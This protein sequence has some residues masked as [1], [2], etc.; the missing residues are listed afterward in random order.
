MLISGTLT[1][2]FDTLAEYQKTLADCVS[3]P[4]VTIN[5]SDEPS[6]TLTA[7]LDIDTSQPIPAE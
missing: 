3:S 5:Y 7:T 4:V 6:L 1:V 2:T